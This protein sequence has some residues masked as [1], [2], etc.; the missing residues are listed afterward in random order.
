MVITMIYKVDIANMVLKS[1]NIIYVG[2]V[3]HI[4]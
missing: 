2:Y 3:L 1:E 4:G